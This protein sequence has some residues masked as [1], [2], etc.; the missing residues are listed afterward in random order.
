MGREHITDCVYERMH[1]SGLSPQNFLHFLLAGRYKCR[2]RNAML[3]P[4]RRHKKTS[5]VLTLR[6]HKKTSVVLSS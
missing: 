1:K 6:M 5:V 3:M 2:D 4:L